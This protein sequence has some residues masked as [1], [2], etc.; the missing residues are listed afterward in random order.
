[1]MSQ[2]IVTWYGKLTNIFYLSKM[3]SRVS[4][5]VLAL[6]ILVILGLLSSW[7]FPQWTCFDCPSVSKECSGE[8]LKVIAQNDPVLCD[9]LATIHPRWEYDN[10][11]KEQCKMDIA[12]QNKDPEQCEGIQRLREGSQARPSL[13][14]SCFM[15]IAKVLNEISLCKRA[16]TLWAQQ[17]CVKLK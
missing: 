4:L 5:V 7:I 10:Y 13:R 14:D 2:K 1:M 12:V 16:E 17:E 6:L 8:Y 15:N 3:L 9:T 11:C